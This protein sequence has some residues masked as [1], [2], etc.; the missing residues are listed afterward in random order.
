MLSVNL[1]LFY[2]KNTIVLRKHYVLFSGH[3]FVGCASFSWVAQ[4]IDP[5]I[6]VVCLSVCLVSTF[7]NDCAD[8]HVVVA[9]A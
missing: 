3:S 2:I 8:Y 7:E 1:D 5:V 6:F 9:V 4:P